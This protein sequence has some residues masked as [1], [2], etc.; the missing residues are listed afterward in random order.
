MNN[1]GSI[2]GLCLL[3]SS[4][5]HPASMARAEPLTVAS[6]NPIVSDL[7]RQVG[8]EDV[9]VI[10]LMPVGANPHNFYPSPAHLKAASSADLVLVAGKG[11]EGY[12]D[13]FRESLGGHVPVYEV[14]RSIPSLRID[15]DEVFI[16]CPA[17]AR[18]AIDPHWW[19]SV[20]STRRAALGLAR[21][22]GEM[23]PE[24]AD[25]FNERYRDYAGRLDALYRWARKKIAGIP[26]RDRELTTSHA[27]FGYLCRE[28]GLRSINVQGL[29]TED[30]PQPAYLK[31]VIHTLRAHDVRAV[32]P[33]DNANPKVLASMISES[34][35]RIAGSLYAG[36][37]PKDNPT[38]EAMMRHNIETIVN[39]LTRNP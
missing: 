29:S 1:N 22:L 26:R 34:G 19:N 35:A 6:L 28:F 30:S 33:E 25:A 15:A 9:K 36:T 27:A 32:F 3:V 24:R 13:S 20:K 38:Y 14:G 18:G 8:G 31:E 39:G 37:P 21:K 17:H 2:L 23:N 16:C 4:I 5:L 10:D 7:A 12:L 11:L